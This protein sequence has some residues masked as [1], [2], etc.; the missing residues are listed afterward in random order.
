[1]EDA[2]ATTELDD[3]DPS[4][5]AGQ[6]NGSAASSDDLLK[7]W[8]ELATTGQRTAT[9]TVRKFVDTL[10]KVVPLDGVGPSGRREV[11]GAA[12]EMTQRLIHAP[13]DIGRSFVQSA[14]L[15]NVNVDVDVASRAPTT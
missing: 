5:V 6:T 12:M 8:L 15:V 10:D 13:Y 11:I 7:Q 2:M 14:V 4:V 9:G 3:R 1:M